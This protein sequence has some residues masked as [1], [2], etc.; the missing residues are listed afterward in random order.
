M[1]E[2]KT[3]HTFVVKDKELKD[4]KFA[5]KQP[6]RR[7]WNEVGKFYRVKF[8]E[9]QKE[10]FLTKNM[11]IANA[12]QHGNGL[13]SQDS[14][15][16]MTDLRVELQKTQAELIEAQIRYKDDFDKQDVHTKPI[17]ERMSKTNQELVSLESYYQ[18]SFENSVE[19]QAE[20]YTVLY[21]LYFFTLKEVGGVWGEFFTG[22]TFAEKENSDFNFSDNED[23]LYLKVREKLLTYF[24]L[25]FKG[26]IS[27]K[28]DFEKLETRLN[29]TGEE[30]PETK[31]EVSDAV[32]AEQVAPAS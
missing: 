31:E 24:T 2:T 30:K 4:V 17:Y 32:Q 8:N 7:E 15:K 16:K 19:A 22:K 23:F 3:L 27:D 26:V 6:S 9:L 12:E 20:T 25:Y 29:A 5:I 28:E 14:V 18:S 10:G 11:I 21:L 13:L 1:S